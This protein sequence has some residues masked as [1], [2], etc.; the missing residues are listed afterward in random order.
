MFGSGPESRSPFYGQ[1]RHAQAL[2]EI[3]HEGEGGDLRKSQ[4]KSNGRRSKGGEDKQGGRSA[5]PDAAGWFKSEFNFSPH[6]NRSIDSKSLESDQAL[7]FRAYKRGVFVTTFNLG[8][9][10]LHFDDLEAW[11]PRG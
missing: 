6:D 5:T 4:R 10:E 3:G 1:S 11:L 7:A 8:E 2:V 9:A